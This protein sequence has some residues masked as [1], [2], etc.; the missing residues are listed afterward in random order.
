[1]T[2]PSLDDARNTVQSDADG[3]KAETEEQNEQDLALA[4]DLSRQN[5]R[6]GEGDE[7]K[8][9][10]DVAGAHGDHLSKALATFTA[11]VGLDL[12]VVRKRLTFGKVAD[13]GGDEGDNE[14]DA[15]GDDHDGMGPATS[16]AGETVKEFESGEFENP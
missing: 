14:G 15:H 13:D 8:V 7:D 4:G 3:E 12:P 11:W 6:D 2:T 5:D 1:M 9:G 10:D 16:G